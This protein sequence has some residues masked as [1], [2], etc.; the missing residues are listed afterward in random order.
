MSVL[1]DSHGRRISNL[2]VSVTDRCNFRCVYCMPGEGIPWIPRAELLRYEEITRLVRIF[3]SLGVSRIRLTGGEPLLR[4]DLP[5]LVR[6]LAGVEGIRDL[7]MTTNGFF[8]VDAADGLYEAGLHRMNVS[9]DSLDAV[10]FARLVRRD[11]F[12]QVMAGVEAAVRL[13]FRCVKINVVIIRGFNDDEILTFAEMARGRAV[14]VR[15]IEFMPMGADDGWAR[16]RVVPGEEIRRRIG[17]RYP[18]VRADTDR[19]HPAEVYTFEDG[20]GEVG[21]ID[22]VTSPFCD[23]CNRVRITADGMF[24]TCLF[25]L[26]ETDL[27]SPLRDGAGDTAIADI[28]RRAVRAKERGHL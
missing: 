5:V 10:R 4:R 17:A 15:F 9:L 12:D 20:R 25:A 11:A 1:I 26:S 3:A 7:T 28:I 8:L 21:F 19:D 27:K 16:E 6:Q 22:S 18:L 23:G 13:P 2:R 24:Q 14:Q